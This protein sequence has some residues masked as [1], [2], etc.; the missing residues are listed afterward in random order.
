MHVDGFRSGTGAIA[1]V[2]GSGFFFFVHV[3]NSTLQIGEVHMQRS[4]ERDELVRNEKSFINRSPSCKAEL[5][6]NMHIAV[7]T[8]NP[9][10]TTQQP[11]SCDPSS[12]VE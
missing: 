4:M 3:G 10:W 7:A 1:D 12:R 6:I 2:E 9:I 5:G 8:C 11:G